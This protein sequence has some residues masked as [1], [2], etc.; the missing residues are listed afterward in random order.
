MSDAAPN[1]LWHTVVTHIGGVAHVR[2]FGP[3]HVV[4]GSDYVI[5]VPAGSSVVIRH[6]DTPRQDG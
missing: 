1:A 3:D 2:R 4:A 5:E 6:V